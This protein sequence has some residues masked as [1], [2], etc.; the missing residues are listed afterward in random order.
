MDY[1]KSILDNTANLADI[2]SGS[3][4][5]DKA[6]EIIDAAIESLKDGDDGAHWEQDVIEAA[7]EL[8]KNDKPLF[9][10]KRSELKKASK[11][12]QI[13]E[14]TKE[15][16]GGGDD[17]SQDSTKADELVGLV[18][19]SAELFHNSRGVCYA[20]FDQETHKE[21]W[22][23]GS[24]GFTDW[25]GFKAYSELGFSPSDIATKQAITALNGLAKYDGEEREVYLRC[26]PCDDGIIIDLSNDKWQ[27]IKVTPQSWQVLNQSE[28]RFTR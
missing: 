6:L 7:R 23:L 28:V 8:F 27:A 25:L 12:A 26:A 10:R 9:Q 4:D 17:D 18:S 1:E 24:V 13:T 15:V 3:Q 5:A 11:D 16:R 2:R 20:T 19:S 21:T 14:W 22:A